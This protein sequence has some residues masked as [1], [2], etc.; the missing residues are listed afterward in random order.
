MRVQEFITEQGVAEGETTRGGFSGSA[1]QAHHEIEWLKNKIEILKPLLAKKPSVARQIKDLERQIRERE[2]AIAYQKK[3][4][5]EVSNNTLKSYQQKV[6]NDTMKHKM[7]PTKRSPEKANRSVSG[8]AK[9]QDRLEQGVAE[10][11]THPSQRVD[12]RTSKRLVPQKSPLQQGVAEGMDSEE[13]R[14]Y[15]KLDKI[16]VKLCHSVIKGKQTDPD[17]YGMVAAGVLDTDNRLVIGINQPASDGTRRHAERVAID[18]YIAQHGKIP[19]GSIIITTCSPCSEPM[20]ER[21]GE[22]CTDLLNASAIKKVYCGYIDPTQEEADRDFNIMETENSNIR[23]LCKQFADTFLHLEEAVEDERP[24]I[25]LSNNNAAKAWIQKIY[26]M[27][28]Q[29]WQNNHIM[30]M[31]SEGGEQQFALFELVPSFSKRGAIEVKWFQAYP[32]RQG[33]GSRAMKQLQQLAQADN[34]TL[35]LFPWDK[36]NV[37][38][39]KLM[40]FY[41]GQGYQP[42]MKG[43]KNM[44]WTPEKLNND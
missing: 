34:I 12:P 41:K 38:Q 18:N 13:I 4:V 3:G 5:A 28:P 16:L 21:Y 26:D 44:V 37:S 27:Y 2:L 43:S 20:D 42:T 40:K 9:A 25:K 32:L 29:K 33:V 39:S 35:T 24:V 7:D 10:Y 31:G 14:N 22:S 1:G 23:E 6:S 8:F 19:A 15:D 30:P 11:G 36:G 17:R